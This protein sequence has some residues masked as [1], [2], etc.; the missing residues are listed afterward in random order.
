LAGGNSFL[1][2][3]LNDGTFDLI[4]FFV[5]SPERGDLLREIQG[6][7]VEVFGQVSFTHHRTD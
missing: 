1:Y 4:C 7:Q 6:E 2:I 3:E 5:T